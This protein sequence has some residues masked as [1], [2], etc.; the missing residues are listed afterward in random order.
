MGRIKEMKPVKLIMGIIACDEEVIKESEPTLRDSLGEID[1]GSPIIKFNFTN[2]Y[3]EEMGKNLLRQWWSFAK[4]ISPEEIAEIK[5]KTNEIEEKLS[6][7]NKRRINLDP[8]YID[9]AK[10][11]LASTK[12][13]SHRI[14]LNNG[15][16]AEVTLIYEKGAFHPLVWTYPDYKIDMAL[17]FFSDVRAGYLEEIK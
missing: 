3:E 17:H 10:L 13:Y 5:I 11:I 1:R 15:I 4:L 16:H 14:Y 12:N 8:G 7:N 9:G 6:I 2:Y